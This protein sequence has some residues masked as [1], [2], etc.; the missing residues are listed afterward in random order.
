M[1]RNIVLKYKYFIGFF[2]CVF[3]ILF[4]IYALVSLQRAPKVHFRYN[5]L[6]YLPHQPFIVWVLLEKSKK[7]ISATLVSEGKKRNLSVSASSDFKDFATYKILVPGLDEG[8]YNLQVNGEES[9]V[10][11]VQKESSSRL[12]LE[13]LKFFKFQKCE[14]CSSRTLTMND[15]SSLD[16]RNIDGGWHDAGDYIRFTLTTSF[17]TLLLAQSAVASGEP[18]IV[19]E[20]LWGVQWLDK[21]LSEPA[22]SQVGDESE[23][24]Y[25]SLPD[26]PA[27]TN[28]IV[29]VYPLENNSGENIFGRTVAAMALLA[30]LQKST[31]PKEASRWEFRARQLYERAL[32]L[33][34]SQP[35]TNNFYDEE[36]GKDDMALAALEM[37][38]LTG[39]KTYLVQA[40]RFIETLKN[41]Y[42]FDYGHVHILVYY[43]LALYSE[44]HREIALKQLKAIF[45]SALTKS[46]KTIF[47]YSVESFFWGC[48]LHIQGMALAALMYHQLVPTEAY[49]QFA[50]SQWDYMLG[51]NQWGVSFVSQVGHN[52][53]LYPHHQVADLKKINVPGYWAPGPVSEEVFNSHK[54]VLKTS[55]RFKPWQ[56]KMAVVHDDV[57]DYITNEPTLTMSSTGLLF[58]TLVAKFS[59]RHE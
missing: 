30:Q 9:P 46:Q 55:D 5:Q 14:T 7:K 17:A 31:A 34:K 41:P 27:V 36:Q 26:S 28:K 2:L 37:F 57:Q 44:P 49:L 3:F 32:K 23:H 20:V 54:I 48:N 13:T 52:N 33:T 47:N 4:M 12:A 42:T 59:K 39:D 29:K 58:A 10:L 38:Y 25:W 50:L 11:R 51:A 24:A 53:F 45:E 18:A 35:A 40:L 8:A 1:Q 19:D 15:G 16:G 43:K 21:M 6:G 56:D 22:L